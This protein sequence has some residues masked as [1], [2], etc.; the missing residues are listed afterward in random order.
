MV[1]PPPAEASANKRALH[2]HVIVFRRE[3]WKSAGKNDEDPGAA[4]APCARSYEL[5]RHIREAPSLPRLEEHFQYLVT[6]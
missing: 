2:W 5:V 6:D 3:Q 1:Y 4:R